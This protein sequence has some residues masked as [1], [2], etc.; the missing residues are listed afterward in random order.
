MAQ[1]LRVLFLS[2]NRVFDGSVRFVPADTRV[3]PICAYG[4]QKAQVE[5]AM[6]AQ[7]SRGAPL[8]I[9]RFTK[10][11]SLKT[12]LIA[13]WIDALSRGDAVTAFRDVVVAPL[14]VDIVSRAISDLLREEARGIFQLSGPED[15]PYV[16]IANYIAK[17]LDADANLVRS[18]SAKGASL[19]GGS[20][21]LHTTL[22]SGRLNE[23]CGIT[24]PDAWAVIDHIL[25]ERQTVSAR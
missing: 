5:A 1:G 11:V 14:P 25:A 6:L 18:S 15:H 8:A 2:S 13:G 19:P 4:R 12:P 10:V 9:A 22:D 17:K 20:I 7:L 3:S 23:L 24:A 21:R 16:D